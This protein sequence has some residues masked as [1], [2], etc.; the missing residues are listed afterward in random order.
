MDKEYIY[1][2]ATKVIEIP[3]Y[4]G[5]LQLVEGFVL[6]LEKMPSKK[7]QKNIERE[8]GFKFKEYKK[9]KK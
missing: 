6:N 8:F 4:V 2:G 7:H 3:N 5:E 1:T 9:E